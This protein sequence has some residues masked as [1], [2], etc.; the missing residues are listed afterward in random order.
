MLAP[1]I[2]LISTLRNLLIHGAKCFALMRR[3]KRAR[4]PFFFRP[5]T[6]YCFTFS[7]RTFFIAERG[8]KKEKKKKEKE[9]FV[10]N[11]PMKFLPSSLPGNGG[12]NCWDDSLNWGLESGIFHSSRYCFNQ[13][14]HRESNWATSYSLIFEIAALRIRRWITASGKSERTFL[15]FFRRSESFK[16]EIFFPFIPIYA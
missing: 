8:Q 14:T 6:F 16:S 7:F 11:R 5:V 2:R 10:S 15:F 9:K 3:I 4:T 1:S 12:K 13:L